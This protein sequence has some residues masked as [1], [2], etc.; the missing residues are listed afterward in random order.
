MDSDAVWDGELCRSR[1][2]CIR[3]RSTCPKGKGLFRDFS[4]IGVTGQ[5]GVFWHRNV[6]DSYVKNW[7][8]FCMHN[9][10]LESAFHCFSKDTVKFKIDVGFCE[11]FAKI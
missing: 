3:R 10:S 4:P 2:G 11:K 9:M 5:N 1:D 6:F 8:Y 7:Q